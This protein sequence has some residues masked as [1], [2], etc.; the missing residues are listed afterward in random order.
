MKTRNQRWATLL[1]RIFLG[2]LL[3]HSGLTKLLALPS[4]LRNLHQS[5]QVLPLPSSTVS[6]GGTV[7]AGGELLIGLLLLTGLARRVSFIVASSL[8]LVKTLAALSLLHARLIVIE[9][10]LFFTLSVVGLTLLDRP[11]LSLHSY[12]GNPDPFR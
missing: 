6:G 8:F 11:L 1:I 5:L 3:L 7:F 4:F 2:I 12:L 9:N 10:G